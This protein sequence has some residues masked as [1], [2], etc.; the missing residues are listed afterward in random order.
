MKNTRLVKIIAGTLIIGVLL[1]VVGISL[2]SSTSAMESTIVQA[3]TYSP[4]IIDVGVLLESAIAKYERLTSKKISVDNRLKLFRAYRTKYVSDIL[5]G[6]IVSS[7]ISGDTVSIVFKPENPAIKAKVLSVDISAKVNI[8]DGFT[9]SD[10]S[11][12]VLQVKWADKA[13]ENKT[14]GFKIVHVAL[15]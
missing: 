13:I 5:V 3:S 10:F 7:T 11:K 9:M 4:D 1:S 2:M 8:A 14:Y 6:E 12:V 15:R